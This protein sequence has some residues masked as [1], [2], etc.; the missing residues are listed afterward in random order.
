MVYK[1]LI[2]NTGG[3]T[4]CVVPDQIQNA[5]I[6][7]PFSIDIVASDPDGLITGI[8]AVDLPLWAAICVVTELPASDVVARITGI[9]AAE[10]E[11]IQDISIVA[12]N[13]SGNRAASLLKIKVVDYGFSDD[14]PGVA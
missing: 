2:E 4:V 12:T 10:D 9:P 11:G 7:I 14:P 1:G 13:G 3:S 6:G 8:E 5:F